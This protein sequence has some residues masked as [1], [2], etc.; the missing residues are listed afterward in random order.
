MQVYIEY[1]FLNNLFFDWLLVFC[2]KG[3]TKTKTSKVRLWLSAIV[4]SVGAILIVLIKSG[5]MSIMAK[6]ALFLTITAIAFWNGSLKKYC[7]NC[8][9]FLCLTALLGGMI[10]GFF[11]LLKVDLTNAQNLYY[12]AN[13][14]FGAFGFGVACF[15]LATKSFV[16]YSK[17]QKKLKNFGCTVTFSLFGKKN[18]LQGLFD[19]GNSLMQNGIPVCFLCLSKQNAKIKNA[20]LQSVVSG[21]PPKNLQYVDF[22]TVDGKA[23][24]LAFEAEDFCIDGVKRQA[25]LAFGKATGVGFDVLV[26]FYLTEEAL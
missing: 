6:V 4:G 22:F 5:L 3:L 2:V 12:L 16:D 8:L 18:E 19:S 25:L 24:A 11:Y 17:T 21:N 7:V 20:V 9:V 26:N 14:P 13:I 23:Q 15:V 1:A 10:L